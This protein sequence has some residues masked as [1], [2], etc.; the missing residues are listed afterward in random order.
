MGHSLCLENPNQIFT[1]TKI[2]TWLDCVLS[3]CA[4]LHYSPRD[5]TSIACGT[6][7]SDFIKSPLPHSSP[8]TSWPFCS[9]PTSHKSLSVSL[10]RH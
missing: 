4:C 2:L 6:A 3:Y 8:A 1:K 10:F 5:H 7:C 9:P